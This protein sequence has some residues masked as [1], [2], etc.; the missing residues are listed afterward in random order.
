MEFIS[1]FL[2]LKMPYLDNEMSYNF[3]IYITTSVVVVI[4]NIICWRLR[5]SGFTVV[6]L[7]ASCN[8]V[9]LPASKRAAPLM[10]DGSSFHGTQELFFLIC[11]DRPF[12]LSLLCQCRPHEE[13]WQ[14]LL[15]L[16]PT[17]CALSWQPAQ[18]P[19]RPPLSLGSSSPTSVISTALTL[20]SSQW[21]AAAKKKNHVILKCACV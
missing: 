14:Q 17:S 12:V 18:T 7:H 19:T 8:L 10:L 2:S 15:P 6:S 16:S 13:I 11:F 21:S 9:L 1:F 3:S 4:I 5:D 20:K